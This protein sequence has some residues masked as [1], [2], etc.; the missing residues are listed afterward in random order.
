MKA[1]LFICLF[2]L[3]VLSAASIKLL[4]IKR[5]I[6]ISSLSL[7]L[8]LPAFAQPLT[9][10]LQ[11]LDKGAVTKVIFPGVNP[12]SLIATLADGTS[13]TVTEAEGFPAYN[14]P[15]SPSGPSQIIARVQHSPKVIVLQDLSELMGKSTKGKGAYE[16]KPMLKHN[17]YPKELAYTPKE[18]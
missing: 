18:Y 12:T 1:S 14:D 5:I 13:Y 16:P 7:T 15:L 4:N 3:L 10:F 6:S 11:D 8:S 2:C 9:S 17:P